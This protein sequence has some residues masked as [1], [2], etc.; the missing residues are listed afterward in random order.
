MCQKRNVKVWH[1]SACED[2][3]KI[4]MQRLKPGHKI[5][6]S[7]SKL[8]INLMLPEQCGKQDCQVLLC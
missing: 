1:K 2:P 8:K 7:E 5:D 4:S 3:P 6:I